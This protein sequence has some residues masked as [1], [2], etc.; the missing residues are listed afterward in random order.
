MKFLD[1]HAEKAGVWEVRDPLPMVLN[2]LLVSEHTES[3]AASSITRKHK[4]Y[5]SLQSF[6]SVMSVLTY[7]SSWEEGCGTR[8]C[9]RGNSCFFMLLI[10]IVCCPWEFSFSLCL[11]LSLSPSLAPFFFLSSNE[12]LSIRPPRS[13]HYLLQVCSFELVLSYACRHLCFQV[14]SCAH[15]E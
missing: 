13:H 8:K 3:P 10:H 4:Q 15:M 2:I 7:L 11:S 5:W 14:P 9:L 6:D 1:Y 12:D